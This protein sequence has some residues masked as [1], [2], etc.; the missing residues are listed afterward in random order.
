MIDTEPIWVIGHRNPDMDAIAS[1]M[2]YAWL[3]SALYEQ[4]YT[5][6]RTGEINAQTAF[7]LAR[8]GAE[9]PSLVQDVYGRVGD[10]IEPLEALR[11]GETLLAAVQRIAA[12]RHPVPI[13]DAEGKPLGLLSG[14]ALFASLAAALSSTSVLELARGL[15][16]KVESVLDGSGITLRANERIRD[17]IGQVLRA[18]Q[19]EFLV[20]DEQNTYVGL[21][22]KSALLAP[23]RRK[24]VMVDH[25]EPQQAVAGLEEAELL[26]VLD[27]HRL[28]NMPTAMPIRFRVEPVG[29]CSTLVAE[30]AFEHELRLPTALAGLLL[31]G[32]LSDTLV[33]RSPTTTARDER[34]ALRLAEM[35]GLA[36]GQTQREA[37][38][39][40][41]RDLLAAGAGLGERRA[42]DVINADLKFYN[43]NGLSAGI[44]QVEVTSF[45]EL[46]PRLPDLTRALQALAENN[47][48]ALAML[49]VTD[50]VRGNSRLV[51]V[52]QERLIGSLP[53]PRLDDGTLDARGV[54][55]RK[56]QL[57]PTVL[58]ALSQAL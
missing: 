3:L 49:L 47:K 39:N 45:S 9:P 35:A 20:V 21:V 52:G 13:V 1:A 27:H 24:V 51:V 16:Q 44:A 15:D 57:L 32:I 18:T 6:A 12:T 36:E 40:L 5:A 19:D 33:L 31:C 7:A 53:Y 50:V 46:T 34:A 25:N 14:E 55:S 37:V 29:S 48:L 43:T 10:L 54:V 11:R 4:P 30:A 38:E 8:F 17:V 42:E 23:P 28:G 22:R 26:E 41:G 2:G 58:A 56:K